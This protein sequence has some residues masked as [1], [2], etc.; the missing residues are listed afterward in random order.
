MKASQSVIFDIKVIS[1]ICFLTKSN[2]LL[3]FRWKTQLRMFSG[4]HGLSTRTPNWWERWTTPESGSTR[5][6]F[7]KPFTSRYRTPDLVPPVGLTPHSSSSVLVW[8][9][10]ATQTWNLNCLTPVAKI[11]ACFIEG[12]LYFV[13]MLHLIW[14]IFEF[15]D[16]VMSWP[17]DSA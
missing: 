4:R 7:S 2:L 13:T 3:Q 15:A 8:F 6:N 14:R 16:V 17:V 11:C 9:T 12:F 5:G 1:P 10:D